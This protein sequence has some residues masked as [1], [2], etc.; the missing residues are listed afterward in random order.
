ME[1]TL[2]ITGI[3]TYDTD[4]FKN[5]IKEVDWILEAKDGDAA[6]SATVTSKLGSP[7]LFQEF[8]PFDTISETQLKSWIESTPDYGTIKTHITEV[9]LKKLE[10]QKLVSNTL[11]WMTQVPNTS[12][13][14]GNLPPVPINIAE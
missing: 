8:V 9:V 10:S 3:R 4:E 7:S 5:I 11:P 13:L 14:V 1:Y 6:Y 12:L 2:T